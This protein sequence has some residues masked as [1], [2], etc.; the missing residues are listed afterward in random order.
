MDMS[1]IVPHHRA[2]VVAT[3]GPPVPAQSPHRGSVPDTARGNPAGPGRCPGPSC[4]R[5][6]DNFRWAPRADR[7]TAIFGL[8]APPTAGRPSARA[9]LNSIAS[10]G[11]GDR[12]SVV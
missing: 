7:G 3:H 10:Q 5:G 6:P 9:Y 2:L 11:F 8:D 4:R 12:K 1:A